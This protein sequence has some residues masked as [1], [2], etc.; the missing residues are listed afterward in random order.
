MFFPISLSDNYEITFLTSV[1]TILPFPLMCDHHL[2]FLLQQPSTTLISL[3]STTIDFPSNHN[4]FFPHKANKKNPR[5]DNP[6]TYPN[7]LEIIGSLNLKNPTF[8][9][10]FYRF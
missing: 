9:L 10:L 3:S 2:T 7:N 6:K 5:K 8:F 4:P 1:T